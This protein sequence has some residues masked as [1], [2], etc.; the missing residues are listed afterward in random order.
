MSKSGKAGDTIVIKKYANRRLYDTSTSRYVTLDHLRELVKQDAEF[1]VLDA[2]SGDDLTRGVLAQIIFEE[3]SNGANMLPLPF[4]RQLIG[5]YGDTLES[6]VPNYLQATMN[7]F[8]EQQE[9]MRDRFAEALGSPGAMMQAMEGQARRNV[10]IFQQT[11]RMFT[12]FPTDGSAPAPAPEAAE[13]RDSAELEALRKELET[14]R[15]KI[16]KLAGS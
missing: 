9:S 2:K 12:P 11:M 10:E 15:A 13:S 7:S 1:V 14:M 16:D 4:L 8:A 5:Y 6:V 3:E